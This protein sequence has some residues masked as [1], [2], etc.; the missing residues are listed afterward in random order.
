MTKKVD[1]ATQTSETGTT[2]AMTQK[3]IEKNLLWIRQRKKDI[4]LEI[5][6]QNAKKY[7]WTV[8]KL[9]QRMKMLNDRF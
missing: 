8:D 1:R 2:T 9:E 5:M 7:N 6:R 3:D 4:L